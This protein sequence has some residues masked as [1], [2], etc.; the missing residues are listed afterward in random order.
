MRSSDH[1]MKPSSDLRSGTYIENGDLLV[2]KIT[3]CF[4]NGKQTI[5]DGLPLPFG[6][7]TT[8]VIPLKGIDGVSDVRYLY[9][10]LTV[11]QVR[12]EIAARMEGATGRQ[13]LSKSVLESWEMALPPLPE[14]QAIADACA[15]VLSTIEIHQ[16]II[17][18][19]R[20]LLFGVLPNLMSG[21][22]RTTNLQ[23][24]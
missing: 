15:L 12:N 19:N 18:R 16:G 23:A 13:R 21:T 10:Y 20:E 24:T 2:S 14:Q 17:D 11:P 8:E 22:L 6:Y 3:P 4:E 5:I 9:F 1:I 7:A